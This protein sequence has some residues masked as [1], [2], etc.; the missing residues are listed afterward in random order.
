[1]NNKVHPAKAPQRFNLLLRSSIDTF[2]NNPVILI[3]FATIAFIQ[4][5]AIEILYFAPCFPLSAFFNP[6]IKALWGGEFTHYP[7]NFLILPKLFQ[8]IQIFIYLFISGY[9]ISVSIAIIASLDDS[10]KIKFLMACKETFNHYIHIFSGTLIM[11]FTFFGLHKI[12]NIAM[13]ETLKISSM[14]GVFFILKRI[15]LNGAPFVNLLIG[16]LITTVFAFIFPAIV[17]EKKKIIAAIGLNFKYL[18]GSFWLIFLTVLI[19]TLFYLP[20]LL[21]RHN[22]DNIEQVSF[23]EVRILVLVLSVIVTMF[24]DVTIY[25]AITTC[26][27]LKKDR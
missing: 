18:W 16:V 10:H 20:V 4:L 11:F 27:L 8:N 1:M 21:L 5:L 17:I 9:F 23:P 14:D 6:I 7:N 15:I 22:I 25:T 2:I 24:I 19:P 13:A 3:P 26:F 12:Y